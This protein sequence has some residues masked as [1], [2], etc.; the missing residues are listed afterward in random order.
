MGPAKLTGLARVGAG[1]T[2]ATGFFT[3]VYRPWH[4]RW[5]ADD[6]EARMAMPGDEMVSR[7]TFSATRAI[8]VRARPEEIW[9]WIVQ[10]GYG[11]AGFYAYDVL[12]L[13]LPCL[14]EATTNAKRTD[15]LKR[16]S[17]DRIVEDLQD[18][19]V[20]T[21]IPMAPGKPSRETAF[22]VRAFETNQWMLW[23]KEASTWCWV[24]RPLDDLC[25]RLISRVRCHY[26]WNRPTILTDLFLMELGDFV[27]MQ[28]ML[29][30]IRQRAE[31]VDK[32]FVRPLE[33]P[34]KGPRRVP[35]QQP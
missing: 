29:R 34:D 19:Q 5:G 8:T 28:K 33:Q 16:R 17:A 27:M 23:E 15:C 14:F 10:V 11:R 9:P 6:E 26:R 1:V 24:L 7:A 35:S 12:D 2:V 30:G 4:T 20:G 18:V 3:F 32:S 31:A 21:W 25:T 22:Q 13:V